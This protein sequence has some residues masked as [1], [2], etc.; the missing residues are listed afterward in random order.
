MADR[1]PERP[2]LVALQEV[3]DVE[4]RLLERLGQPPHQRQP[5]GDAEPSSTAS[6]TGGVRWTPVRTATMLLP[7]KNGISPISALEKLRL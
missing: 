1:D 2:P 6:R 7:A 4:Q 5:A 3:E